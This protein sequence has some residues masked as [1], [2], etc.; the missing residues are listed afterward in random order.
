MSRLIKDDFVKLIDFI[1]SYTIKDNLVD[2][3]F[4]EFSSKLHKKYYS[5]LVVMEELRGRKDDTNHIPVLTSKQFDYLQESVSDC[6][7][8]F[9][10]CMHGCYK[11]AK[12]ILRSSIETFIR[13]ISIDEIPTVET[14]TSVFEIFNLLNGVSIFQKYKTL[15]DTIHSEYKTLCQDVHTAGN[16]HMAGITA[17]N[18]FPHYNKKEGQ[19]LAGIWNRLLP[20]YITILCLK[21]NSQF[22]SIQYPN[23][24]VV[25]SDIIREY[26]AIVNGEDK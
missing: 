20:C 26:K 23:K 16:D 5:Y 8:S 9:F 7:Q 21:F 6:G 19:V 18:Y 13:A 22:H 12:L 4:I 24:D 11:G 17:L 3:D 25:V 15:K 2:S 1:D 14:E 10:L